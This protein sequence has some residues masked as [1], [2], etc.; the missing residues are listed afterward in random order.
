LT[1]TYRNDKEYKINGEKIKL[2]KGSFEWVL[3]TIFNYNLMQ[4]IL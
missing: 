4:R 1:I 2:P 3:F